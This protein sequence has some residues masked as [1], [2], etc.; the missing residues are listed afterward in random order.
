MKFLLTN[1]NK[2]TRLCHPLQ[3]GCPN[4]IPGL[5]TQPFWDPSEFPWVKELEESY[6]LILEE[7]RG[8]KEKGMLFQV[9]E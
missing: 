5:R 2:T 3:V 8:M 9:I 4:I 6:T 7:F 1:L